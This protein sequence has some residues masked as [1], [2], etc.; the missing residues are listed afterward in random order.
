[1]KLNQDLKR[2]D[3]EIQTC[4]SNQGQLKGQVSTQIFLAI[5]IDLTSAHFIIAWILFEFELEI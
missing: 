4:S 1:M 2:K 3:Q 5:A